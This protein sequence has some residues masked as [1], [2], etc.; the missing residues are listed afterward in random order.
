M[1]KSTFTL[2]LA[3]VLNFGFANAAAID[4]DPKD[5]AKFSIESLAAT[6]LN[7]FCKAIVSGNY[8]M[9]EQLIELGEDIN[10][11][12]LGRTPAMY[13]ARYNKAEI[14]SLLIEKGADISLKS[15]KE[16]KTAAELA[17]LSNAKDS[18]KV[19][20]ELEK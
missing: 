17:E 5:P 1:R 10:Q 15:D 13:A 4:I 8:D 6:N 14:L 7:S 9:V 16:N 20:K 3:L 12:S 18:M 2:A 11:K 19:L